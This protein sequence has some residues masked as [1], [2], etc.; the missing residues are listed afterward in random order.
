MLVTKLPT[1]QIL[2]PPHNCTVVLDNESGPRRLSNANTS[3]PNATFLKIL[4]LSN[5]SVY[6][7]VNKLSEAPSS[8]SVQRA[9]IRAAV[10]C[11][12]S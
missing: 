4:I 9:A 3:L 1:C 10:M 2:S 6:Y 11:V 12:V 8:L 5:K 7:G